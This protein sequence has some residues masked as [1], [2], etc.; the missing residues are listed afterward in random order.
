VAAVAAGDISAAEIDR[1]RA[2]VLGAAE[3]EMQ[4]AGVRAAE[5]AFAELYGLDGTR[6]R[7]VLRRAEGVT[8]AQ[9]VALAARLLHE[10]RIVGSLAPR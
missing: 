1:A 2:S 5:A 10:P 3:A 9:V 7:S 6:Y 8:H 4:T